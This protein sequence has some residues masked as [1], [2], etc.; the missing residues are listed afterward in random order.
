MVDGITR[1]CA[2]LNVDSSLVSVFLQTAGVNLVRTFLEL[3]SGWRS[4]KITM[5][6]NMVEM[7]VVVKTVPSL[8]PVGI[9]PAF[10]PTDERKP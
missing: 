6:H 4:Q 1:I 10:I 5:S 2:R 9:P 7:T 3:S 8:P